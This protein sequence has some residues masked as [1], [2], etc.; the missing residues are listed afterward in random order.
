MVAER[1]PPQLKGAHQS[2]IEE[3]DALIAKRLASS[4]RVR[5]RPPPLAFVLS[6]RG[7]RRRG[8]KPSLGSPLAIPGA[9]R[10]PAPER[11]SRPT[12]I[13]GATR[14]PRRL[15][16]GHLSGT[17]PPRYTSMSVRESVQPIVRVL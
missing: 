5:A 6:V 12:T 15:T 14:G 13:P 16:I 3:A 2:G 17:R 9:D 10:G 1:R 7:D 4:Q 11:T 8:R